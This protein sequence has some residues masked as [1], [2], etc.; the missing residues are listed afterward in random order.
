MKRKHVLALI[1]LC[2]LAVA[3]LSGCVHSSE[4]VKL[5]SEIDLEAKLVSEQP[6]E[7]ENPENSELP[8][9]ISIDAYKSDLSDKIV[10]DYLMYDIN[11]D[12]TEELI[13]AYYKVSDKEVQGYNGI[14]IWDSQ[15]PF[16][17]GIVLGESSQYLHDTL[18]I[19]NNGKVELCIYS[20]EDP[21]D[22]MRFEVH[23]EI[24]DG[25]QNTKLTNATL[26]SLAPY[27]EED[28]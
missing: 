19:N 5:S 11:N 21:W 20:P 22:I 26:Y 14:D 18:K 10:L 25:V 23:Y 1:L 3:L 9:D 16:S 28:T 4:K 7:P 13:V 2:S 15:N 27:T 6:E 24:I 17:I 8:R 12:G